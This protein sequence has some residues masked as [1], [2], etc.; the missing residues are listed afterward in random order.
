MTAGPA[1]RPANENPDDT[2]GH[3]SHARPL[4]QKAG[5]TYDP[6]SGGQNGVS[7][8]AREEALALVRHSTLVDG[9]L[10]LGSY[11]RKLR[12]DL[13]LSTTELSE[14]LALPLEAIEGVESGEPP[15]A[16]LDPE[17]LARW[18]ARI[19]ALRRLTIAL[20]HKETSESRVA[21][22]GPKAGPAEKD[23]GAYVSMFSSAFQA[24][25]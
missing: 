4:E 16:Q 12:Q 5:D 23:I 18:A 1:E 22:R 21:K 7:K 19:G 2:A 3:A 11:F 9:D 6:Q 24:S 10:S 15:S 8:A 13:G 25:K 17:R 20:V 14:E